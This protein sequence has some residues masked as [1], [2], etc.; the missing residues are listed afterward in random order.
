MLTVLA[1]ST[2]TGKSAATWTNCSV[3]PCSCARA[4]A[5]CMPHSAASLPST[6]TRMR[7]YMIDTLPW[8]MTAGQSR[9]SGG[10]AV[11]ADQC[12]PGAAHERR[13]RLDDRQG[14]AGPGADHGRASEGRTACG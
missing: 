2:M 9:H 10:C 5:A 7:L 13:R 11:A 6:G 12:F 3:A 8:L 14:S 4:T 1:I